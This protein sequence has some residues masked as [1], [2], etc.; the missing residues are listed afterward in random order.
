MPRRT[1]SRSGL[2][3]L[4]RAGLTRL[5]SPQLQQLGVKT[6]D[7]EGARSTRDPSGVDQPNSRRRVQHPGTPLLYYVLAEAKQAHQ[8]LGCVSEE[9]RRPDVPAGAMGHAGQHPADGIPADPSLVKLTPETPKFSLGIC[10]WTPDW[11]REAASERKLA[12]AV[13]D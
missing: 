1:G 2:Q 4:R 3:R 5:R 8:V 9:H 13:P 6:G 12:C 7:R 10:S 11:R